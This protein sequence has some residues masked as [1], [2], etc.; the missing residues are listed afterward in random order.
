M[1]EFFELPTDRN[2]TTS[3]LLRKQLSWIQ[4]ALSFTGPLNFADFVSLDEPLGL[5]HPHE[6]PTNFLHVCF[7]KRPGWIDALGNWIATFQA[8][9]LGRGSWIGD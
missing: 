4:V 8:N 3:S 6:S 2:D 9:V 5:S 7:L 1:E